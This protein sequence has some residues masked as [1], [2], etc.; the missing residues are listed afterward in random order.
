MRVVPLLF[1]LLTFST[2]SAQDELQIPRVTLPVL[3]PHAVSAKAFAPPGWVLQAQANGDLNGDGLPDLVFILHDTDKR[4]VIKN[5][6]GLGVSEIDTNPRILGVA[7]AEKAGGY[8]LAAQNSTLIPRWE[9]STQDDNFGD[10][11]GGLAV[12]RGVFNVSL[13]YFSNA[14]GWDAGSTT[15]TFRWQNSRFELIGLDNENHKRNTGEDTSASVNY[16]TGVAVRTIL[17][18][19]AGTKKSRHLVLPKIPLKTLDNVGDG[20]EFQLPESD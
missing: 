4:N 2:C 8:A 18:D 11:G 16:S 3:V 12:L 6:K 13:H 7:F 1:A 5:S 15:F 20:M 10:E 14:G 9:S 17:N 19:E